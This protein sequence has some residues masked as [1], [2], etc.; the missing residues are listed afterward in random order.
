MMPCHGLIT[1]ARVASKASKA[2]MV[3]GGAGGAGRTT[4]VDVHYFPSSAAW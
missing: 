2:E 1:I 3:G 4:V